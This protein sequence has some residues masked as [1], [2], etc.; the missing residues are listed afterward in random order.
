VGYLRFV[1]LK[2]SLVAAIISLLA[3]AALSTPALAGGRNDVWVGEVEQAPVGIFLHTETIELYVHTQHHRD[4]R[5]TV[6]IPV[7]NIFD[8]HEHCQGG[9]E[10][11]VGFNPGGITT[12]LELREI[13][14]SHRHINQTKGLEEGLG[15]ITI[16]GVLPRHGAAHGTLAVTENLGTTEEAEAGREF[17]GTCTTGTLNWSAQRK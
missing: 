16:I 15:H 13:K 17:F 8:L 5:V 4:G 11:G 3:L 2:R 7:V 1:K 12:K 6:K 10:V 9:Q 14:V